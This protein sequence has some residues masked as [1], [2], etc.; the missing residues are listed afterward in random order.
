MDL[1]DTLQVGVVNACAKAMVEFGKLED[2]EEI[3]QSLTSEEPLYS[4]FVELYAH[5]DAIKKVQKLKTEASMF[6]PHLVAKQ[7]EYERLDRQMRGVQSEITG[8]NKQLEEPD[9]RTHGDRLKNEL[10]QA[11]KNL[12]DIK[13][14]RRN[15]IDLISQLQHDLEHGPKPEDYQ[16]QED[17]LTSRAT[18]LAK[19]L[20]LPSLNSVD[21]PYE[22]G[23]FF[24][25]EVQLEF[26]REVRTQ[27]HEIIRSTQETEAIQAQVKPQKSKPPTK[28]KFRP[29]SKITPRVK[30][31]KF[32]LGYKLFFVGCIGIGGL[33]GFYTAKDPEYVAVDIT[34][35]S[36]S[37]TST[38]VRPRGNSRGGSQGGPGAILK[39][40]FLHT[41]EAYHV[42]R[43]GVSGIWDKYTLAKFSRENLIAFNKDLQRYFKDHYEKTKEP[44]FK[45][46]VYEA[47]DRL[48]DELVQM[49]LFEKRGRRG[50]ILIDKLSPSYVLLPNTTRKTQ[51]GRSANVWVTSGN[52]KYGLDVGYVNNKGAVNQVRRISINSDI[53]NVE[54][55]S[56]KN[57]YVVSVSPTESFL[58]WHTGFTRYDIE[59]I[60]KKD[61]TTLPVFGITADGFKDSGGIE[62][63]FPTNHIS[64]LNSGDIAVLIHGYSPLYDRKS[65]S[66]KGPE[67]KFLIL[68]T[69]IT[70]VQKKN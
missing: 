68:R 10:G 19:N 34:T 15:A 65:R 7:K 28:P 43:F 67:E 46:K 1:E 56:D 27:Y 38:S 21:M 47:K 14:K 66:F 55:T 53:I 16:K 45:E 25:D 59:L 30:R 13:R 41:T 63:Q 24:T 35:S 54:A 57:K 6:K 9:N 31:K 29:G 49:D 44:T 3:I 5:Y 40:E 52:W 64:S 58:T 17:S 39:P 69:D 51:T 50:V 20:D 36:S 23:L 61:L 11:E 62:I 37:T 8:L 48:K 60:H 26:I 18:V 70:G 32:S 22:A 33:L 42:K 12:A 4:K 2:Q